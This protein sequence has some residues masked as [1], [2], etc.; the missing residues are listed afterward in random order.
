MAVRDAATGSYQLAE[1]GDPT[2]VFTS[3]VGYTDG[4]YQAD[5]E[6][7]RSAFAYTWFGDASLCGAAGSAAG[8]ALTVS[9]GSPPCQTFVFSPLAL[10]DSAGATVGTVNLQPIWYNPTGS[11]T[12][13]N[14]G[15][16]VY[17]GN[18]IVTQVA[19]AAVFQS[20]DSLSS[21]IITLRFPF[22]S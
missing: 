18:G 11:V 13:T 21:T 9:S 20:R 16:W 7:G 6:S 14:M 10:D 1:L 15:A 4:S 5:F 12:S 2:T 3:S 8:P 17:Y 19:D 22:A